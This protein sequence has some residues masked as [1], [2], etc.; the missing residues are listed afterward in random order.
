MLLVQNTVYGDPGSLPFDLRNRRIIPFNLS[1]KETGPGERQR[2][3]D[4]L[5]LGLQ[6]ALADVL[7]PTFWVGGRRPRWFGRWTADSGPTRGCTLFI[8]EVGANG[9]IFHL[10]LVDGARRGTVN[11]FAEFTGPDSAYARIR[12]TENGEPCELKFR[13]SMGETRQIQVEDGRGCQ[14]FKGMGASFNGTYTCQS[15]LLFES[16]TLDE[17]DLQRL[18]SITGKYYWPLTAR[19]QQVGPGENSDDFVATVAIGGAKGLYTLFEAIVMKGS[20]GQL[21]AAYVDSGPD[22][23]TV[24]RKRFS[25]NRYIFEAGSAPDMKGAPADP[26]DLPPTVVRYFTTE[27]EYKKRLPKTI[28]AWR[29]RFSEREVIFENEIDTIPGF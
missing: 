23:A 8:R 21:W 27:S 10:N 28:E 25:V 18:Y 5:E 12:G 7:A 26:P 6:R 29:A 19:F 24:I 22:L 1:S 20:Q 17:M 11:G 9:F 15:D 16:G 14:H 13:R 3:R 4:L 2:V